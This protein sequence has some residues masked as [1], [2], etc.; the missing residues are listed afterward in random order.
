MPPMDTETSYSSP[1][2]T[3]DELGKELL[4]CTGRT[5]LNLEARGVITAKIRVGRIV[6]FDLAQVKEQL[7][8]ATEENRRKKQE[9]RDQQSQA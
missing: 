6:R 1:L 4:N 8:A 7:E 9:A 3:P 5:F 2:L